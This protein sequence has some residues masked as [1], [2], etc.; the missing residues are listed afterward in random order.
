M[1]LR[2]YLDKNGH[3][4]KWFSEKLGV[5]NRTMSSYVNGRQPLGAIAMRIMDLTGGQVDLR[6]QKLKETK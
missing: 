4:Q 5:S 3:T 2:E 6:K 1:T